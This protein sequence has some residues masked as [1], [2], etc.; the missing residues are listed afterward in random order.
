MKEIRIHIKNVVCQRCIMTV[1][2]I[3]QKLNISYLQ[4]KLG[5]VILHEELGS[6]QRNQV[7]KEFEKVGFEIIQDRNEKII[8]TIKSLIIDEIYSDDPSRDKLSALL[9]K[10]LNYD[11]SHITHLFTEIEGH[12]IQKFYN[13]I[14]IERVKELLH[15]DDWS[16]AMIA[17]SLGYS[18]PAYLSTSFKK[19]TGFTPSEYKNLQVKDR[20]NL[21]SV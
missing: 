13:A 3:L 1:E 21:D 2:E 4:V 11:Y 18:T 17:D 16:I 8:N 7:Q 19:S 9:T 5:E 15:Y 12:S 10:K 6:I 14:R 20:K